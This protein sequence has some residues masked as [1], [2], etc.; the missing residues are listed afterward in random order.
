M[1]VSM[2]TAVSAAEER[3]D[4]NYMQL[5]HGSFA[6][7]YVMAAL[8]VG[9]ARG[10]GFGPVTILA[11]V[12]ITGLVLALGALRRAQATPPRTE[13]PQRRPLNAWLFGLGIV[14]AIAFL[15]E[16]GL[17]SWTALFLERLMA[18]PPQ[19]SSI[20]PATVGF[21]VAAGR[22]TA[23]ALGRRLNAIATIALGGALIVPGSFI[24]ASASQTAGAATGTLLAAVGSSVIAPAA[25]SLAGQRAGAQRRA[26]A[27]ATVGVIA[28]SG[29]FFGPALL[30]FLASDF[31]L[32]IAMASLAAGG[33]LVLCA[34][35]LLYRSARP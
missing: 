15:T 13:R 31:G 11:T 20:A 5:A 23:H 25:L 22:L 7:I 14:A 10:L 27:V 16:N 30:G 29:F 32:R 28:Y 8:V 19:V 35:A 4:Q 33:L 21:G 6:I 3:T 17:Q 2:N 26:S 34:A 1:D 9:Q 18:A 12:L 24:L